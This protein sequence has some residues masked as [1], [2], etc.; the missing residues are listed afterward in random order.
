[1]APS[2]SNLAEDPDFDSDEEIDFSD[3]RE[4]HEVRMEQGLDTF[5]VVDGLPVVPEESKLKLIKFL[6]KKLNGAGKT[7]EDAIFMPL[8]ENKMSEG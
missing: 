6:L 5:V 3:L 8:N 4:Q 1:M 2:F 7:S